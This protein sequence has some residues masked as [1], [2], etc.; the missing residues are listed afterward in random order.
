[1]IHNGALVRDDGERLTYLCR[2]PNIVVTGTP[3]TGKSTLASQI[4]E[5]FAME[6]GVHPLRHINVGPLVKEKSFHASYDP[7]WDSYEVD[8]DQLLDYL[9]PLT[10]GTAPD[11]LESDP[12]GCEQARDVSEDDETRG[13]LVLDWHTCDAWPERWVDLVIVL[14]CDHQLLWKRL[15]RRCVCEH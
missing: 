2:F 13:G 3:G 8:E 14:R 12:E 6:S 1:M 5:T 4:C 9:E 10:G 11:S 15:E 7:E